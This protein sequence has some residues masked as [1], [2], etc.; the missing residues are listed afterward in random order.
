MYVYVSERD[1]YKEKREVGG[2]ERYFYL[3]D[4]KTGP[5]RTRPST[6]ATTKHQNYCHQKLT[7]MHGLSERT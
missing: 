7:E 4:N 1:I 5:Q 6:V 2:R 3:N